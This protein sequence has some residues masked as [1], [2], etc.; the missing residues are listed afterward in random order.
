M[1]AGSGF[2]VP[3]SVSTQRVVT[4]HDG[5]EMEDEAAADAGAY[6][7]TAQLSPR[8]WVTQAAPFKP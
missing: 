8:G 4:A 5:D 2:T 3:G 7:I 6:T 1:T